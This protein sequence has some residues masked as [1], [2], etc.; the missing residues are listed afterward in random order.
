MYITLLLNYN[1]DK[2]PTCGRLRCRQCSFMTMSAL[3]GDMIMVWFA[4]QADD[5]QSQPSMMG[6]IRKACIMALAAQLPA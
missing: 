6:I 1:A 4:R 3:T 2:E 5:S